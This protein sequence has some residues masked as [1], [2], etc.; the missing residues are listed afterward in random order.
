[1]AEIKEMNRLMAAYKNSVVPALK[2]HFKYENINQVPRL[3]KIVINAGLGDVKDNSKSFQLAVDE[4]KMIAGQ[5]PALITIFTSF[6]TWL[7]FS[8]LKC[9][10]KAGTTLSL[11][12]AI[13][14]F[15]S[16]TSATVNFL[17]IQLFQLLF[18]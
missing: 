9:S 17:L 2:E 10:F 5:K 7:M 18:L 6:G 3:E 14:L 1:M 8:Y 15:I 4:I 13:N 12:A 16:L 11:Y